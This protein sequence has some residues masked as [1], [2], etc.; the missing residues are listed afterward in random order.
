MKVHHDYNNAAGSSN[1]FASFG[2]ETGG[3][4]WVHDDR[5]KENEVETGKDGSIV[6]K[7]TGAGDWLPGRLIEAREKFVKFDPHVKHQALDAGDEGWRIVAYTP[8]GTEDI[9]PDLGKFLRNCG[10]PLPTKRRGGGDQ[11]TGRPTKKQRNSITNVVGKLSVLFTTLL[12]AANSFIGECVQTEVINDP[13]VLLE[14]GGFDATLGATELDKAVLEPLSWEDY[15][16]PGTRDRALHLVKAISPRQLHLHLCSA[17]QEVYTDLKE[18]VREQL[19]GGGAVLLQGGEP[20]AVVEDIDDFI[21]YKN[22][23]EGEEWTVLARPGIKEF[24]IPGGLSPH[25]VLVMSEQEGGGQQ[26]PLRLDGSGITFDK[27]V[28]GHVKAALKR[29]HQN[30]GH[31]RGPDLARHLRLAGCEASVIKA[32]KG[33]KCQTCDATKEPQVARP[34]TLPRM[35]SFGEVV[36]ADILYAHDC[37]DK[38]HS[39]LSLVDVG[40]T[41]H[42]VIKLRNTGGKEIEQA[43][44]TYW[45]A[46]FGA[47]NAISLDLETGLQDGFS[48]LCSWHNVKIRNSATQAHFQSG[49]GERQGKWFKNIWVRVCRELSITADEAQLAATSVC[50]AKNSLRR[51]CGHSPAAWIFG[52]ETR[53]IEQVL[54]P[55]SGGRVTFDISEDAKFQRQMAIR[56]SAR[57]AF[58]QS[59]NDGK[60][61][62]ALLQRARATTRPFENGE[63]VHYWNLPKNRRQGRWEGPAIVVGREGN[64]YWVSRNGRCRL[65]APEH[66]R[67]SGPDETGEFLAMSQMK[68]ELEQLLN[69][70][71]D[72][73][74][75]FASSDD[76]HGDG[77]ADDLGT[78]CSPSD[79]PEGDIDIEGIEDRGHGKSE[80]EPCAVDEEGDELLEPLFGQGEEGGR[81]QEPPKR[82]WPTS[83][84]KRKT[85]PEDVAWKDE[86]NSLAYSAMLMRRHLTRRG[87]EKRQEKELRWDEIPEQFQQKFREAECKQ[88]R[89]HLHYDALEPLND[90]ESE[91]VKKNVAAQ[92]VLR[93][94]WA[95]KDKNWSKRKV[96]GQAEW[97]C[98]SR[99]VIAG[100]TDPDLATGRLVTD[101]PTL[102]RPGLLCLLQLLANGLQQED[103]WRVSAGDIQCAFLTGSYLS[104][105]EELYIHQPPTGFPGM[106][107]G[108]LVRVKKNIFGLATSPREWWLDLQEGITKIDIEID[109]GHFR[110]E[111]CP[112]DPCIFVLKEYRG[113]KFV[114]APRGYVGTHVDDLLVI[115][116]GSVSMLVE[117]ALGQ[118]FPVGDWESELFNYLGSEIYYGDN[119]AVLSQQAY[120]ESRL[121]SLDVPRG[122]DDND[123]AGPDLVADN[124]SLV[125]ALSWLSAQSRPDLTC[126]VSMAQQVQKQPTFADIRFTNSVAKKA[127]DF[128]EEGLRFRPIDSK[129]LLIIVYHDAGW[130]NAVDAT[131]DEEG[132]ELTEDDKMAG[133]QQEGPF[134]QKSG[135]KAKR[136]NTKVASQ[137]GDL[138]VFA[139]KKCVM[140]EAGSFSVLDWKSRAGQRVCRST[141][142]AETQACIEGAEAGQ[143]VRALFETLASGELVRVEDSRIPMICLSDCRSLYDHV[144]KQ[145]IPRVPSDRRLAVDLAALR[146]TLKAE[147]WS[148]KLPLGWVA[149]SYQLADILT[150]PQDPARWWEVFRSKLLVPINLSGEAPTNNLLVKERRTSVKPRGSFLA[151]PASGE[152]T[153]SV[154]GPPDASLS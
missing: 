6:W 95:Y 73:E 151:L 149:S 122:V 52:R 62:K 103:P 146:Q 65:T 102:S 56:A 11:A 23:H 27:G 84:M 53:E 94:R 99:L 119:E 17:P 74:D 115:A 64:N 124:R 61:R 69:K 12:V 63:Q 101:A 60:L 47:P 108:Q 4:L 140:G 3:E 1:Y 33:M 81:D 78:L 128:K 137:L 49:V 41:Y 138:I 48:R 57:V 32:A 10:F 117:Q 86:D 90:T 109:K 28:P 136:D 25:H 35:L 72:G 54:D 107:P 87:L 147:Q 125:G 127:T 82:G 129:D 55:D 46:P 9:K 43:F 20:Q 98:K 58:H 142:S 126:S 40:T 93:S 34:A 31:P 154:A 76:E 45:L 91:Y 113:G 30:L 123:L 133:L 100:H 131:H 50:S 16:D 71:F 59:E 130:A 96:E 15:S 18:L 24:E 145:G 152:F 19:H 114:G 2:Q 44:N 148:A 153:I 68:K 36:C 144:H 5:I 134:V 116:P 38:R 121:F 92:R 110:F 37:E 150:K 79:N 106:K 105:E 26:Q 7:R 66:L 39:F 8:R 88:W 111:Q 80:D 141:F 67:P 83:R 139:E 42:V 29:L 132:F 51:R 75:A 21:R 97:R 70:D 120:A 77:G 104:R 85:P 135:R 118:A 22:N 14:I 143:H 89:E 112:L 13:I